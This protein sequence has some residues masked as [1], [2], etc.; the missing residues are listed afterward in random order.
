MKKIIPAFV[1]AIALAASGYG[2][3]FTA[4]YDFSSVLS[5]SGGATDP[6]S[7]PS[8]TGLVF[9][10]FTAIGTP[11]NPNAAGRFSFTDWSTGATTGSDVF[12]GS[13]NTSEY[14]EVTIAPA[15]SY[16]L[17][18]TSIAFTVQ[19]SGTGIRQ[20][21]VRS[22]LDGYGTNLFA[23]ISP[24]NVS[25]SIV[26]GDVFQI[27]DAA[28][29]AQNGSFVSLSGSFLNLAG[30]VTFRFYG[31]NSEANTGTFSIDNVEF[32]GSSV[33]AIP[34]PST[35]AAIMGVLTLGVVLYRRRQKA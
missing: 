2:Q 28:T 5:G 32:T 13:V 33:T 9:G 12:S 30:P 6:T 27:T 24:A 34:E 19:R 4:V 18:L 17:D 14:F 3:A 16:T 21:S 15:A 25:L 20:Y 35:Y 1:A 31:W 22:S 7:V 26:T 23:N 8:A 11:A 29:T 10:S